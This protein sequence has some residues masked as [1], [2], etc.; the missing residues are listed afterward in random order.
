[1]ASEVKKPK[2]A[3]RPSKFHESKDRII[4]AIR[5]GNTM[6]VGILPENFSHVMSPYIFYLSDLLMRCKVP[7]KIV[8]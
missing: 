1:M 4:E 8:P 2:S 7:L 6:L 5:R 3:G